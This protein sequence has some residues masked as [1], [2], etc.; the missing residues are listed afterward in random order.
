MD[1]GGGGGKAVDIGEGGGWPVGVIIAYLY[2][3]L[4][5]CS[6]P[7]VSVLA[8]TKLTQVTHTNTESTKQNG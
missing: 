1:V 4:L 6:S 3:R 7:G 2:L 8:P 5:L